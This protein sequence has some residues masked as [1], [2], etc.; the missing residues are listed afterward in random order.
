MN[1]TSKRHFLTLGS[2]VILAIILLGLTEFLLIRETLTP[3]ET[4]QVVIVTMLKAAA[5]AFPLLLV[6]ICI[7]NRQESRQVE[8]LRNSIAQSTKEERTRNQNILEGTEAGTWDW[9]LTTSELVLNE[10]WA[11]IIGYTLQ[12]LQPHNSKTWEK[13]LH[14][15]DLKVAQ[16]QI[17]QHLS[18]TLSYYDVEFRQRHKNGEWK[19]VN[20]RGKITEWSDEGVPLRISGTHLD[21]TERKMAEASNEA[22]RQILENVFDATSGISVIATNENGIITLFNSGAEHMLGYGADEIIG[23]TTPFLFHIESEL[24]ERGLAIHNV[25]DKTPTAYMEKVLEV[26]KEHPEWTYKSKDGKLFPV[27]LSITAT[28]NKTGKLTGYLGV[29]MDISDRKRAESKLSES[30]GILQKILDTIPVRVFWKDINSVYLGGNQLFAEDA[31]K[32]SADELKGLTDYQMGWPDQA[33]AFRDDDSEVMQSGRSK[34]NFEEPQGRPDGSINWLKTSKI[35]LR[36]ETNTIIGVLGTY[37]DITKIKE[38]KE[39]L[40]KAKEDAEAGSRA[41]DEFLAIMSHEMRTPLNP[42][43][44]FADILRQS[45][46]TEPEIEYI[47]T[48]INAANRQLCLIDDILEYMRIN[49]GKV[50]P[51]PEAFNLT[52]LCELAV[53]DAKAFAGSLK[54]NFE[55]PKEDSP[56]DFTVESD[57]MMLRRILDNLINNACKYT[58]E[59]SITVSLKRSVTEDQTFIISVSDTGIGIDAQSQQMLFDAF[60]QADSSYTRKHEGLGLGLAI[61]KKLLTILGGKIEVE[62]VIGIGSTFTVYLPLKELK[63]ETAERSHPSTLNAPNVFEKP[64]NVL[65]VDDQSDNRLIARAYIESF[66]GHVTDV[67][68]G[69]EAVTLCSQQA[70]DVI[71]MD[72]AMPIMNGKEATIHIRNTDNPNQHTPIIAVTAD[73]TPKVQDACIAV[74]MQHYMSKPINAHELFEHINESI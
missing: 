42:I 15:D 65:V 67:A 45:I 56:D 53:S 64:C 32:Q 61:C 18:G 39:D 12:E 62:S 74:G 27:K 13:T 59:G 66:G 3:E 71:L 48:I 9:D 38:A 11:E 16:T 46:T 57:L 60:S 20:A 25:Q 2:L 54:L 40:V 30:R 37:E 14:P 22:N 23:K 26:G 43:I 17:E 19:W 55:A 49:G 1:P 28:Y 58:H 63:T 29:A 73:V 31:G 51:S 44:G 69:K 50:A 21:I 8:A 4:K 68:N 6:A 7:L 52:D 5:V 35:P 70:F 72:L 33:D 36:D 41:K 24:T 47:D 10:R 34:L